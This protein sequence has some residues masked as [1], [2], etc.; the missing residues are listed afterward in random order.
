MAVVWLE[1]DASPLRRLISM[2]D[3][4]ERGDS[5][6]T[7]AGEIRHLEDRYGLSPVARRRLNY[8]IAARCEPERGAHRHVAPGESYDPRERLRSDWVDPA[9]VE[10]RLNA[11]L[12]NRGGSA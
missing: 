7:L 11:S 6:A 1:I 9:S 12:N 4:R 3:A 10:G 2:V 8:E 5:S